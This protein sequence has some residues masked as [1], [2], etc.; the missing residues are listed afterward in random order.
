M[1]PCNGEN[2]SSHWEHEWIP[3]DTSI[4]QHNRYHREMETKL[5]WSTFPGTTTESKQT[6][7]CL[8]PDIIN[9][10]KKNYHRIIE[11]TE[12]EGIQ[13]DHWVKL[14]ALHSITQKNPTM[15]PERAVQGLLEL[16]HSCCHEHH[17]WLNN[18]YHPE[19]EENHLALKVELFFLNIILFPLTHLHNIV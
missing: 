2:N 7:V 4:E 3:S 9:Q 18:N 14:L 16:F 17:L 1:S 12:L 19:W 15:L 11:H 13:R 6:K 10:T 5:L 8:S